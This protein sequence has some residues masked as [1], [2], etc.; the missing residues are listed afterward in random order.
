[1]GKGLESSKGSAWALWLTAHALVIE[2]VEAR[3]AQQGLP[4]LS[5]YDVLWG[6]ERSAEGRLRLSEL[7]DKV[8]LS[9]S[10]LTRLVDRLEQAKL[11]KRERSAEDRRGAYAVITAS[12]RALRKKMWPVYEAAIQDFFEAHLTEADAR[13]LTALMHRMIEELRQESATSGGN[14]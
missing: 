3:L 5:W 1:M 4:S 9:R 14:T 2:Q 13:T 10:N 8:V 7:A 12:G 11:V 6:L